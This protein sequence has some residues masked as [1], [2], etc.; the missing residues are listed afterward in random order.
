[1]FGDAEPAPAQQAFAAPTIVD[2]PAPTGPAVPGDDDFY[3][4]RTWRRVL[5][6]EYDSGGHVVHDEDDTLHLDDGAC[7]ASPHAL[8]CTADD[9]PDLDAT[10]VTH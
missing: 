6:R 3:V 8:S 1:M 5:T 4:P 2:A 9:G 7:V 10:E